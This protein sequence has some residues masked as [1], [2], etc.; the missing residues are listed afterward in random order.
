MAH[1]YKHNIILLHIIII[2]IIGGGDVVV[3]AVHAD[4][5]DVHCLNGSTLV[6]FF[7]SYTANC[8]ERMAKPKKRY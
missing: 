1:D 6:F 2:I 4:Y 3:V 7:L 8:G 5:I